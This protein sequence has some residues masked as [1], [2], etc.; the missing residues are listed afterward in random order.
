LQVDGVD[1]IVRRPD[2][3]QGAISVNLLDIVRGDVLG[4]AV[5][6][7]DDRFDRRV[8]GECAELAS[9]EVHGKVP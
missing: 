2:V 5:R 9:G 3:E 7:G 4:L 1:G 8:L 6:G